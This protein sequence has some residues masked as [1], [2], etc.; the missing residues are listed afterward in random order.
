[1]RR[2][3]TEVL[4]SDWETVGGYL[5]ASLWDFEDVKGYQRTQKKDMF[6]P[7]EIIARYNEVDPNAA[8]VIFSGS[9]KIQR[10]TH[11][12][13]IVAFSLSTVAAFLTIGLLGWALYSLPF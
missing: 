6:P 9:E 3:D 8:E 7:P 12:K 11:R 2:S 13:E 10:S 5:W 1:M 4:R